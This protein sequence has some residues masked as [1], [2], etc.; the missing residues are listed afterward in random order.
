MKVIKALVFLCLISVGCFGQGK[1]TKVGDFTGTLREDAV[2]F[3]INNKGYIGTGNN[4]SDFL[5]DFWEYDPQTDSWS[6]KADF[7]GNGREEAVAFVIGNLG[8]IT[9][10]RDQDTYYKDLWAY[11]PS[12]NTWTQKTNFVGVGRAG[13]THFVIGQKAYV[14]LGYDGGLYVRTFWEYDSISDTWTQKQDYP[15]QSKKYAHGFVLNGIG[16]VGKGNFIT[17][18]LQFCIN[19][20]HWQ[21]DPTL[22]NWTALKNADSRGCRAV[23]FIIDNESYTLEFRSDNFSILQAYDPVSDSWSRKASNTNSLGEGAFGFATD[24][25]LFVLKENGNELWQFDP[26]KLPDIKTIATQLISVNEVRVSWTDEITE[27]EKYEIYRS[28]MTGSGFVKIAEVGADIK[29]Y[30]DN[31]ASS[32][33]VYFYKV[34]AVNNTRSIESDFSSET[35]IATNLVASITL[36]AK[37]NPQK[38]NDI[39]LNWTTNNANIDGYRIERSKDNN[40][41]F[42]E[43][44]SVDK[45]TTSF[46]DAN[47]EG[48]TQ[49]FYRIRAFQNAAFSSY[50][51][52]ASDQT[53]LSASIAL[54]ASIVPAK[55]TNIMLNWTNNNSF[56]D[57]YKIERTQDIAQGYTEIASITGNTS[58]YTDTNL[59]GNSRYYYRVR[60]FQHSIFSNYSS[61]A[62]DSTRLDAELGLNALVNAAKVTEI[63]LSWTSNNTFVESYSIE[64]KLGADGSFAEIATVNNGLQYTDRNLEPNKEYYYRIRATQGTVKSTYSPEV[65]RNT[66][67]IANTDLKAIGNSP[68]TIKLTWTT[69]N[70]LIDGFII[71]R[72]ENELQGYNIIDSTANGVFEYLDQNLQQNKTYFYQIR[73]YQSSVLSTYSN[74]IG[75]N[76]L[77]TS[78]V[79]RLSQQIKILN[80]PNTTGIFQIKTEGL[81]IQNWQAE[82]R[83]GQMRVLPHNLVQKHNNGYQIDLRQKSTGIYFLIFDTPNGKVIKKMI[84]L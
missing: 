55:V 5:K 54:T 12:T 45:N 20:D 8:Y 70:N 79:D 24:D 56:I 78:T 46:T 33:V 59:D 76:T 38:I 63:G 36:T 43:I 28:T 34:K 62:D 82:L 72:A 75:A 26:N 2:G 48:D 51:S 32:D 6:Q 83:D 50:S 16:Y 84:K 41:S 18:G 21:Y 7:V 22:D 68:S 30:N 52:E 81:N 11:D 25:K 61:P 31:T 53:S 60:A 80:N 13:A 69:N 10:G 49:Y 42:A 58:N 4:G 37:I 44:T 67:L 9:L 74:R 57:G 47:L 64:R 15:T 73:A 3:S 14:G 39:I 66:S 17:G 29:T 1:W 23:G 19:D 77:V 40:I 27:E 35:T 65:R 71:E